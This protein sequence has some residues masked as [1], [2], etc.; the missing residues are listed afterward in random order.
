MKK[1]LYF[2]FGC[3]VFRITNSISS[4]LIMCALMFGNEI[5]SLF[6][7]IDETDLGRI[8][9]EDYRQEINDIFQQ[10]RNETT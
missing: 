4:G 9:F 6:I 3:V 10:E 7:L 2:A 1:V 8:A 5:L